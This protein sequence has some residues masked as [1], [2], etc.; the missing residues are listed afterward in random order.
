MGQYAALSRRWFPSRAVDSESM[1]EALFLEKDHWE[2][3]AVAVANG[4][5]KAFRG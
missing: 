5:A 1:A 3:M 2:K 4:I